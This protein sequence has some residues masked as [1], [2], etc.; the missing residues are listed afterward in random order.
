ML[1]Q[2]LL[3][4][5]PRQWVKNLFVLPALVFSKHVFELGY[6]TRCLGGVACFCLVSGAVYLL[7]DVFDREQDRRHPVKAR[8]PVASGSLSVSAALA[9]SG[10][11]ALAGAG[12]ALAL[13]PAFGAVVLGYA[14]LNLAYSWWLKHVVLLDVMVVAAGFLLRAL[15]GGVVIAVDIST[16][17]VLCSFTLALFMAVVKRRQ[18]L[19]QLDQ[20]AGEHRPILQD[21]SLPFL[22]QLISVLTS[23]T[24]VCYA[25]YA[26]GVGEEPARHRPLWWTIPMVLYGILRYL[27]VVYRH[28]GGENPTLV[29]WQDRPL[30]LAV[31]LWGLSS[32]LGLYL[33]P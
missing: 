16:W 12:G 19:A 2:I 6:L 7:N 25:L 4:M 26:M 11:L 30:Q 5:R 28:G 23:A 9:A 27:Y 22:D 10:L 8:R 13:R 1:V 18:E 17:F 21:Y 33:L 15:G 24:L 20:R 32:L 29:I 14:G 31:L 3:S